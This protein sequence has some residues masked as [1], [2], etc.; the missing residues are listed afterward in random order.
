MMH[1]KRMH[2]LLVLMF[3]ECILL[4]LFKRFVMLPSNVWTLSLQTV[5]INVACQFRK[6]QTSSILSMQLCCQIKRGKGGKKSEELHTVCRYWLI[7]SWES[8]MNEWMNAFIV[9]AQLYNEIQML[10]LHGKKDKP[11]K[12][13]EKKQNKTKQKNYYTHKQPTIVPTN[14]L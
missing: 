6:I 10:L 9:I 2:S 13:H 12:T 5:Q 4:R 3:F 8:S 14:S 11:I 7:V 1:S